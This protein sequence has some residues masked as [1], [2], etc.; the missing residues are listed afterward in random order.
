MIN[1]TSRDKSEFLNFFLVFLHV[2]RK[3]PD[4]VNQTK[5]KPRRTDDSNL[6]L[7]INPNDYWDVEDIQRWKI[8]LENTLCKIPFRRKK[9]Q[10]KIEEILGR[11][12]FGQVVKAIDYQTNRRVAIKGKASFWTRAATQ[13][14]F[15]S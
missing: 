9:F 5:A 11:G 10:F 1:I 3:N 6:D 12:S 14:Y 8:V 2:F 13:K 15:Q 4:K 7:K